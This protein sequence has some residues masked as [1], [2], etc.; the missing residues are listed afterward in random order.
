MALRSSLDVG[1]GTYKYEIKPPFKPAPHDELVCNAADTRTYV[2][3]EY[4]EPHIKEFCRKWGAEKNTGNSDVL[5][6]T[7]WEGTASETNVYL[8]QGR[9][10]TDDAHVVPLTEQNCNDGFQK[11]LDCNKDTDK[12]AA[13]FKHG[14][15]PSPP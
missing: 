9:T 3:T 11:I 5:N 12:N 2:E 1:C 7:L 8:G 6:V 14:M 13:S 10:E 4:L 15:N